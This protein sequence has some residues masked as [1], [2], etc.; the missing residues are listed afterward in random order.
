[1][2]VQKK[3]IGCGVAWWWEVAVKFGLGS[4]E[5]C[6]GTPMIR[7]LVL[8]QRINKNTQRLHDHVQCIFFLNSLM[9]RTPK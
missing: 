1:M 6:T 2:V 5:R 9:V 7:R 4:L 3:G 8:R